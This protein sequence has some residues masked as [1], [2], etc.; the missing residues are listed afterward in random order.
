MTNLNES[1][2]ESPDLSNNLGK[3]FQHEKDRVWD[4]RHEGKRVRDT[5]KPAAIEPVS[6]DD[7][8]ELQ[9]DI[10]NE[11]VD[12][13]INKALGISSFEPEGDLEDSLPRNLEAV[14][15][16]NTLFC[17]VIL[18]FDDNGRGRK[19]EED[20]HGIEEEEWKELVSKGGFIRYL[21][22][23]PNDHLTSGFADVMGY[24]YDYLPDIIRKDV[25][26]GG[27]TFM[28]RYPE[29]QDHPANKIWF[30]RK[31]KQALLN[32]RAIMKQRLDSTGPDSDDMVH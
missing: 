7:F 17:P 12:T 5:V 10:S 2:M 28:I 24:F 32:L 26:E 27:C 6:E 1:P 14:Y 31:V 25:N 20:P 30:A 13:I 8:R 4:L 11:A 18:P 19:S 29:E 15:P 16:N 21:I 3:L 22:V 23:D 9:K